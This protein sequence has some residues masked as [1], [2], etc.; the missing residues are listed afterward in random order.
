MTPDHQPSPRHP[1]DAHAAPKARAGVGRLGFVSV[2]TWLIVINIAVF[3]LGVSPL[4]AR[5][6][7]VPWG[8]FWGR[9]ATREQRARAVTDRAL[10]LAM[11]GVDG[12]FYHPKIDPESVFTGED[13]RV[14]VNLRTGRPEPLIIGGERFTERPLLEAIGHF[15]TG[16]AFTD[17]Q[18]WRLLTFQFLHAN[19]VHLAFNM[20][21]LWFIGGLVE[22]YLG[23]RRYLV[24]YLLSGAAGAIMYLALNLLGFFV[25]NS[26]SPSM[27]GRIP[28]LLFDDVY[29]PLVGASAGVFGVLLAAA[30]IAPRQMVEVAFIVPMRLATAVYLFLLLAVI[31]LL[32]GG[33]N[34]GGDAAHVGGALAG[35]YLIRNPQ[36]LREFVSRLPRRGFL[37]ARGKGTTPQSDASGD[38]TGIEAQ[39]DRILDKVDHD[40][41]ESLTPDERRLLHEALPSHQ[42]A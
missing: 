42:G 23:R 9:N 41:T 26:L 2:N 31:N 38:R 22:E 19:W 39:L 29:T 17:L 24:F 11:P 8:E 15:S 30:R 4:G 12:V 10:I 27:S 6:V 37:R 1:R 34:A 40:G 33:S 21:G 13:G 16:K 36:I 18:I 5:L 25:L 28:A 7:V 14:I 20:L 35:A 32:A 3:V